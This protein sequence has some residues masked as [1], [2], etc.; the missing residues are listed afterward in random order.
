MNVG[1]S[2]RESPVRYMYKLID[3][4]TY[5]VLYSKREECLLVSWST[6]TGQNSSFDLNG[7][8]KSESIPT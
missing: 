8:H 6:L 1:A 4:S 2:D 7:R 5:G 3:G